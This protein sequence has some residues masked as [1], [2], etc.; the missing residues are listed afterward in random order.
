MYGRSIFVNGL[1]PEHFCFCLSLCG[2]ED[3]QMQVT[4]AQERRPAGTEE[5]AGPCPNNRLYHMVNWISLN[6]H[7]KAPREFLP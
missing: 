4:D 1:S 5:G 3:G 2:D 6:T 7:T